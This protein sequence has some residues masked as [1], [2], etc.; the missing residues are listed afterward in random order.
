MA[1]SRIS[2][3]SE[4]SDANFEKRTSMPFY[5]PLDGEVRKSPEAT[6]CLTLASN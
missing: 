3:Y 5:T 6:A 2:N 1:L 4:T